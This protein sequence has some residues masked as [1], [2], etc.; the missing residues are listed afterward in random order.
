[1]SYASASAQAS[2]TV[3]SGQLTL[4]VT[5]SPPWTPGQ[6]LSFTVGLP[7][8]AWTTDNV[9][10][11]VNGTPVTSFQI[12]SGVGGGGGAWT[13][14][15]GYAGQQISIYAQD[16]LFGATSNTV[17]G[18]VLYPTKITISAPSTVYPNQPFTVSGTLQY[19]NASGSWVALAGAT[20]TVKGSWGGSA[21][22]TTNS[23][24]QYS[25]QLTAPSSP[26]TYTVTASFAGSSSAAA[27]MGYSPLAV[28]PPP[29]APPVVTLPEWAWGLV[30]LAVGLI[31]GGLIGYAVGK[32]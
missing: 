5:P 9:T 1:M 14:P 6:T 10:I 27:A 8:V 13:I 7:S 3:Q 4:T 23:S 25:V 11:Y 19:Q 2:I 12:A 21:T 17:T 15:Q 22:A 26:G 28:S 29:G 30:G 16:S 18:T 24:G 32:S 31:A 20:V